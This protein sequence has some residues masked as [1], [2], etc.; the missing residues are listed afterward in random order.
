MSPPLISEHPSSQLS[1]D[2]GACDYEM[3]RTGLRYPEA[4]FHLASL[5]S[6]YRRLDTNV[7]I[8]SWKCDGAPRVHVIEI[9]VIERV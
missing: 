5:D 1:I 6:H 8:Q 3:L 9:T 7:Y 2:H 4:R